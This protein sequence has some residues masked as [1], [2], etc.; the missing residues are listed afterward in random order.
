MKAGKVPL[1]VLH[2]EAPFT[3]RGQPFP[4]WLHLTPFLP[5][6]RT[7]RQ[8]TGCAVLGPAGSMDPNPTVPPKAVSGSEEGLNHESLFSMGRKE[9]QPRMQGVPMGFVPGL[10]KTQTHTHHITHHTHTQTP[11]TH[12]THTHTPH[13][14]RHHT[15][16]H[17]TPHT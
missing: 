4:A 15:H 3:G 13:T 8:S 1:P 12:T 17:N 14:Y 10:P 6:A 11:H 5:S 9:R 16:T 2:L 7:Q